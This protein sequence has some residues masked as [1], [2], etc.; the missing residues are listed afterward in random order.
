MNPQQ[1]Y[2]RRR[3]PAVPQRPYRSVQS[4]AHAPTSPYARVQQNPRRSRTGFKWSLLFM[5][6]LLSAGYLFFAHVRSVHAAQVAAQNAAETRARNARIANLDGQ[7]NGILNANSDIEYSVSLID[8]DTGARKHFG[9]SAVYTAASTGKLLTAVDF[10]HQVDQGQH[11]LTESIDGSSAKTLLQKMIVNSDDTAWQSLNDTLTHDQMHAYAQS[12][13]FTNYDPSANT[14]T[15]NDIALLLKKLDKDQ[16]LSRTNTQLLLSYMKGANYRDY[17][18]PAVPANDTVYHKVGIVND[19]VHDAAII[20][21]GTHSFVLV[22]FSNG[23]GDYDWT[24]R[25][26]TM[27]QITTAAIKAYL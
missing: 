23:E 6:A 8:L 17:I 14:L 16:L 21:S 11:S 1:P 3:Q 24:S 4:D 5:A 27:Q 15:S 10:L 13:G 18:V 25:A 20:T 12:I 2:D 26:Q 19:D 9:E 22:I 7:I